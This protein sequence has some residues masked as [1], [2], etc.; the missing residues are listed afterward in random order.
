MASQATAHAVGDRTVVAVDVGNQVLRDVA[1]PIAC[2]DRVRV[3]AAAINRVRARHDQDHL[4]GAVRERP[5]G[6][7]FRP[8]VHL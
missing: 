6:R 5:I 4:I 7:L 3:H 8:R 1:F 2:S